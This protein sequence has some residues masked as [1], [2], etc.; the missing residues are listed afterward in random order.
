MQ[1]NDRLKI[2]RD[3]NLE[4]Y[5]ILVMLLIIAHH[6]VVNSG[7]L[8]LMEQNMLNSSSIFLYL[9]GMWGKTGINCFVLITGYFMC[10]S[11]ITIRKFLKLLFEIEFY[12]ILFYLLFVISGYATFSVSECFKA[13]LP[14]TNIHDGFVSCF[15]VFY[16]F[17]PF[18]NI[19]IRNLNKK[20]HLLLVGLCIFTYTI[21]GSVPKID[22]TMNYVSWFC[23]LYFIASYIR[24]YGC[25]SIKEKQWKWFMLISIS[26][27]IIS[28]ICILKCNQVL[29]KNFFPYYFV[30]D[31]NS[32]FAVSTAICSFMFFKNLKLKNNKTINLISRSTF[33]VLLIHANSNIMRQ[34]LWKDTFENV[35]Y[36]SSEYL[37]IHLLVTIIII[38]IVCTFIDYLRITYIE[39]PFFKIIDSKLNIKLFSYD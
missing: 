38:Y 13:F 20:L 12:K 36:F 11:Q 14:I 32:I 35:S 21:L 2:P 23:V 28:V 33:G 3:S 25:F 6:Y 8:Q 18:L 4:L 34:W 30:S 39:A 7:L 19:L 24:N 26:L 17:I 22:V 9:A 31:C 5:R 1:K 27:S 15:L 10:K 29:N 16:L 37:W